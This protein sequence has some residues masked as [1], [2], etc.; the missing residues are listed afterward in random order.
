[1][2]RPS[3]SPPLTIGSAYLGG[4]RHGLASVFVVVLVGTYISLGALAHD[5]GFSAAWLAVSTMLVWAAP[6]QVIV[7]TALA[8][9]AA[10]VEVAIAVSLSGIRLL[11]MAVALL[12]ILKTP[13]TRVREL[14]LPAHFTAVSLWI[15]ALRLVPKLPHEKRIPFVNGIGTVFIGLSVVFGIVGFY[16]ASLL[17]AAIVAALLFVT[18][19]SFL[20]S[21]VRNSRLWSDRI[22]TVAGLFMA[23]LLAWYGVGLDLLWTGVIAGTAGY[24]VHRVRTAT[25]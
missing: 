5:L 16:L 19:M 21:A 7:C 2:P 22:A 10:P 6:A 18:P 14:L 23:P 25:Q 1:M 9:G 17:P 12:P 15:E 24:V 3:E 8:G 11:P 13:T 20:T 4:V